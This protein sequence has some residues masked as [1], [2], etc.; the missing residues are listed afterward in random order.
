MKGSS[1]WLLPALTCRAVSLY[2]LHATAASIET[3]AKTA[4][5]TLAQQ[6]SILLSLHSC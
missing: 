3:P 4:S 6:A 1:I 5:P 2:R